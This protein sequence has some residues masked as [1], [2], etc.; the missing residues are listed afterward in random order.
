VKNKFKLGFNLVMALS[1][2]L[3][4]I[5]K[6]FGQTVHE[7]AGLIIG[8]VF[9]IHIVINWNSIKTVTLRFLNNLGF[10]TRLTSILNLLIFIGFVAVIVSGMYI[11]KSIDFSWLGITKS[12]GMGWKLLHTSAS[13]LTFLLVGVHAGM[14]FHWV[15]NVIKPSKPVLR[16]AD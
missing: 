8:A 16:L 9:I 3:I 2:L 12:G 10:R 6:L 11:S 15:L 5:P 7:W 13:Y 1:L 4:M 14:N